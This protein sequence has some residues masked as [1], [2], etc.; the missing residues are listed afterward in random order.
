[1][2]YQERLDSPPT[3]E[4]SGMI[5][6]QP[7]WGV[8]NLARVTGWQ[9]AGVD[10]DWSLL[11]AMMGVQ[12]PDDYQRYC[13]VFPPGDFQSWLAVI[14]PI[15][16]LPYQKFIDDL[17]VLADHWTSMAGGRA[18]TYAGQNKPAHASWPAMFPTPGGLIPWGFI[19]QDWILCWEPSARPPKTW[20]SILCTLM[21][22]RLTYRFN[23]TMT[24]CIGS[25]ISDPN[26]FPLLSYVAEESSRPR[27]YPYPREGYPK[28]NSSSLG[29]AVPLVRDAER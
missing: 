28:P 11:A 12:L 5:Y 19:E 7:D 6:Q 17:V 16:G 25:L 1:M 22:D 15:P 26:I 9:G 29:P 24:Q 18:Q 2:L 8:A 20:P 27:F 21:Y 10:V 3:N 14:V 4:L 23:G 13:S